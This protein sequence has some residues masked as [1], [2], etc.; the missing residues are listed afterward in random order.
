MAA[1]AI[2]GMTRFVMTGAEYM[3]PES[4]WSAGA[5]EEA[6][7]DRVKRMTRVT[8]ELENENRLSSGY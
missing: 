5:R 1:T 4:M 7:M 3:R 8:R 6:S 2:V